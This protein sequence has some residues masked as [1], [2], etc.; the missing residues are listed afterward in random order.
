MKKSVNLIKEM[1]IIG[2]CI[3][4]V[5]I[6]TNVLATSPT[7]LVVNESSAGSGQLIGSN[8]YQQVP[9]GTV[10][11]NNVANNTNNSTTNN[12]VNNVANNTT[13]KYITNNSSSGLP[14]TGI[15]DYNIGILLIICVISA[16][17]AYNKVKQYKNI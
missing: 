16:I 1:L 12:K 7:G 6:S 2:V 3:L 15:E 8:Q 14:Q 13:K 4:I 9:Q 17:Y 11:N 10:Q 5:A